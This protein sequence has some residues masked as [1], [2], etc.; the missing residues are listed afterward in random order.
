MLKTFL[1][2]FLTGSTLSVPGVSGGTM[3][4]ILGVYE[5]LIHS[6][7]RLVSRN[8][9]KKGAVAFLLVFSIGG[10]LGFLAVSSLVLNLIRIAPTPMTFF[11]CGVIAGGVP[12][13]L[14][15]IKKGRFGWADIL[16]ILLGVLIVMFISLLPKDLF[17]F[18]AVFSFWSVI[19]EIVGGLIVAFAL[20]LPGIS[21]SHMLYVLGIYEKILQAV[22]SMDVIALLP[23]ACGISLG[24][25]LFSRLMSICFIRY[26]RT[27]FAVIFGF[28][29]GSVLELLMQGA[30]GGI[31]FICVPLLIIG[32]CLMHL[33][34]K[35]EA[36]A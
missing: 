20:I 21:V 6:V 33:I 35:K 19:K 10:L 3:A 36:D 26:R 12:K 7:N 14:K 8:E 17:Q 9:K 28:V 18:D 11:F 24:V 2:G 13:I 4:M 1:K 16:S 29:I 34:L 5:P 27:V 32:Y 23:M 30:G 22:S 25:L 31:S 15:E